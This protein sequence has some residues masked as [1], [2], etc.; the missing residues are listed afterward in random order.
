VESE[1]SEFVGISDKIRVGIYVD[2]TD[3]TALATLTKLELLYK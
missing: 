1:W 2:S 3:I